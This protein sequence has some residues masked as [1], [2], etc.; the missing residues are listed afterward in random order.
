MPISVFWA[1]DGL[2]DLF[3]FHVFIHCLIPVTFAIFV[4]CIDYD[5]KLQMRVTKL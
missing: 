4:L 2:I 5:V 1:N 3:E